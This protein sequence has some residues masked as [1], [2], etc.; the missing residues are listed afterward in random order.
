MGKLLDY[1]A[2][3][4]TKS[5]RQQR[6]TNTETLAPKCLRFTDIRG[7][8]RLRTRTNGGEASCKQWHGKNNKLSHL[9]EIGYKAFLHKEQPE[10][11]RV[12]QMDTTTDEGKFIGHCENSP[13]FNVIFD[14][15]RVFTSRNVMFLEQ[16][17]I[18]RLRLHNERG[19]HRQS[20]KRLSYIECRLE[21]F[22]G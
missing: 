4:A 16:Y 3:R 7:P 8:N 11:N 17:P 19:R 13:F 6:S 21:P 10:R 15:T 1:S 20:R 9:R 12:G 2:W 5:T 22:V 18:Q 14:G